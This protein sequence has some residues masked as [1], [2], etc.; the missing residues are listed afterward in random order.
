ML[1]DLNVVRSD[2]KGCYQ[3]LQEI[4]DPSEVGASDAPGT[5]HQEHDVCCCVASTLKWFPWRHTLIKGE[6]LTLITLRET[7]GIHTSTDG[8]FVAHHTF[9]SHV[10]FSL[11]SATLFSTHGFTSGNRWLY[12]F[13]YVNTMCACV[14]M[15]HT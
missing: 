4:S 10:I 5:V 12:A 3:P 8:V 11:S 14:D 13:R 1:T 7:C 9:R 6:R 15:M 2:A